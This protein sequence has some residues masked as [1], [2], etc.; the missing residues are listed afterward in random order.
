LFTAEPTNGAPRQ[1]HGKFH[2]VELPGSTEFV[3]LLNVGC[4][5]TTASASMANGVGIGAIAVH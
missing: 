3:P 4:Q 2:S 5:P 1:W